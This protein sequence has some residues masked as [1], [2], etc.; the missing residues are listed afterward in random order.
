M[1]RY[2]AIMITALGCCLAAQAQQDFTVQGG[3]TPQLFLVHTVSPKEN[4]Y[5]I[6]RLYN[7]S[8]KLIAP[9][10]GMKPESSIAIGQKLKIPLSA[11]NLSLDGK[12][13]ADEVLLP[14]YHVVAE[15]EW[16]YRIS[17]NHNKV[18][19]ANLEAWNKITNDN[20]TPGLKLIVGYLKVKKGQSALVGNA[21]APVVEAPVGPPKQDPPPPPAPK[22]KPVVAPPVKELPKADPPPPPPKKPVVEN[23]PPKVEEPRPVATGGDGTFKAAY[24]GTNTEKQSGLSASFKTVSGWQDGKYYALI[25]N[26]PSGTIIKVTNVANGK[27]IYA[28]VLGELHDIKMNEGL[29]LRLSNAAA[30]VLGVADENKFSVEISVPK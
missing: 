27:A 21:P 13:G 16:L 7:Q 14:L 9:L 28:K 20:I 1:F 3:G 26:I 15:K 8:P 2:L 19:V 5:S 6:G 23:P 11:A 30:S 10:N 17:V 24:N 22:E 12:A 18:P 29:L 25:D 4:L